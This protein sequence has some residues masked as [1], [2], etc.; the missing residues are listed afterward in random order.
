MSL[1]F[2]WRGAKDKLRDMDCFYN[3]MKAFGAFPDIQIY[4]MVLR[5]QMFIW[6]LVLS[7]NIKKYV[8]KDE[9]GPTITHNPD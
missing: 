8:L 4:Y 2:A 5:R 1:N 7:N 9:T 3:I 6:Q